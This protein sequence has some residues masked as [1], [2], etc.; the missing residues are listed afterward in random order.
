[1]RPVNGKGKCIILDNVGSYLEF[2]LPDANRDWYSDFIG[3]KNEHPK[4]VVSSRETN[5]TI[6]EK[7]F[8]E[9]NDV[10]GLIEDVNI[11]CNQTQQSI[12]DWS[13]DDDN[14]L[15]TLV[16]DRHCNLNIVASVFNKSVESIQNRCVELSISYDENNG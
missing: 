9:G 6:K 7:S 16:E 5:F 2:G 11:N 4:T 3:E 13:S 15:R 12:G 8:S 10:I 1:M 14:L